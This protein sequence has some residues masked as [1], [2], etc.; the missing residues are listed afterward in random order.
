MK[1]ISEKFSSL[2]ANG[3][4]GLITYLTAGFPSPEK[5]IALM[6]KVQDWGTD[7]LE[8]GVPFSDPVADGPVIQQSSQT[9]LNYGIT[10][11]WTFKKCSYLATKLSIPYLIMTYYNPIY[12][13]GLKKFAEDCYQAGVSGVIVP[14]LSLEES[15]PLRQVLQDKK[16]DL[17]QFVSPFTPERRMEKIVKVSS[18]FIYVV[19]VAGVTGERKEFD[20]LL[21]KCLEKLRS[22]TSLPLAVGFG[23]S[24]PEQIKLLRN[25]VDAVIIG[26]YFIRRLA[27]GKINSL[28]ETM[29][30]FKKHLT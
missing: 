26:S 24:S 6:E 5:S 23:V 11:K 30:L 28:K 21:R 8:I 20:P 4:K 17:I 18:G 13:Y 19:S 22:L 27:D 2:R 16:V 14:D 1:G 25:Y 9:A 29:R 12:Q 10:L 3:E 7:L 15:A